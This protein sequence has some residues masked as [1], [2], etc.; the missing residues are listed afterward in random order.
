MR[1]ING[2]IQCNIDELSAWVWLHA[3]R[4][5]FTEVTVDPPHKR[6]PFTAGPNRSH[7][8]CFTHSDASELL[9]EQ[10][11]SHYDDRTKR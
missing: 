7:A 8:L 5:S 10:Q 4:N 3:Y 6:D 9:S 2:Q 1:N 11:T